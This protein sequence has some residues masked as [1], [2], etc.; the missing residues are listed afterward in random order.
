MEIKDLK[1]MINPETFKLEMQGTIAWPLVHIND[2]PSQSFEEIGKLV[3]EA[4][5][6]AIQLQ[7][8]H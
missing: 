1:I 5:Y 2:E 8:P 3:S 7:K 6:K 4:L